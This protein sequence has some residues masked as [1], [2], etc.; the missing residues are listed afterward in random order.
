MDPGRSSV[1]G[2]C[3]HTS[4][5]PVRQFQVWSVSGGRKAED[6][7]GSKGSNPGGGWN[8]AFS[9]CADR[10]GSQTSGRTDCL[11]KRRIWSRNSVYDTDEGNH[12]SGTKRPYAPAVRRGAQKSEESRGSGDGGGLSGNTGFHLCRQGSGGAAVDAETDC[13]TSAFMVWWTCPCTALEREQ[14]SIQGVGI[15][16]HAAA[17][18]GRG[19]EAVFWEIY[20][21]PAGCEVSGRMSGGWTS[22]AVGRAWIL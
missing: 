4:G 18:Q 22:E 14:A 19:S 7:S 3:E 16:D 9:G 5:D 1:F 6:V 8:R 21:S 20:K 10:T 12:Q 2:G 13:K 11:Q 15:G 17:D